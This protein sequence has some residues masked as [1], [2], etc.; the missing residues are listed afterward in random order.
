MS[1]LGMLRGPAQTVTC[2]L[3]RDNSHTMR[4]NTHT[5]RVN[6][7]KHLFVQMFGKVVTLILKFAFAR[8]PFK[9][10]RPST[11]PAKR[12]TPP[13]DLS[14]VGTHYLPRRLVIQRRLPS[15]RMSLALFLNIIHFHKVNEK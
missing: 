15:P 14:L 2:T 9:C 12:G 6:P 5:L 13:P 11:R 7:H 10:W 1:D 8:V 3:F 4:I